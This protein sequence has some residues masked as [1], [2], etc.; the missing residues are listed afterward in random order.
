M[1]MKIS[2]KRDFNSTDAGNVGELAR[3]MVSALTTANLGKNSFNPALV[4]V[5]ASSLTDNGAPGWTLL[6]TTRAT[7]P[8]IVGDYWAISKGN[9]TVKF[10]IVKAESEPGDGKHAVAVSSSTH[11]AAF[12]MYPGNDFVVVSGV[13]SS[14]IVSGKPGTVAAV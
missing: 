14:L 1:Y 2:T 5:A 12:E 4:D 8:A 11:P 7:G 9:K 6:S 3:T 13:G 10:E